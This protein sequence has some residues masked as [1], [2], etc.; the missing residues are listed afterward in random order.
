MYVSMRKYHHKV[1]ES[2]V[3]YLRVSSGWVLLD[4]LSMFV[5]P[6]TSEANGR[7]RSKWTRPFVGLSKNLTVLKN[8][9]KWVF[10]AILSRR[11]KLLESSPYMNGPS[12]LHS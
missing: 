8:T 1:T 6:R 12:K 3:G 7:N 2:K 10:P 5:R 11:S 9:F 4:L